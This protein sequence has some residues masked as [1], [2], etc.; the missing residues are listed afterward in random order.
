MKILKTI[1]VSLAVSF[2]CLAAETTDKVQ[3]L[4]GAKIAARFLLIGQ[5]RMQGFLRTKFTMD[6]C[7]AWVVEPDIPAPDGRWAWC[8][9]WPTAFQDRVGVRALLAAG[10]RWVT[11]NPASRTVYAGNQ[12]DEMIAKRRAF[13]R[14]LVEELGYAPKCGLIGMSWGGYYSVRYASTHPECVC[15]A[16]LDAPLLDFTTLSGFNRK[17]KWGREGLSKYY[18]FITDTYV[19][20]DDPYQSVN[21][22][23]PIAKAGIPLLILYGGVDGVVPP[24]SNCL[25]FAAAFEKAGGDL[26]IERRGRYGH[27]P[28]GVEPNEVQR[29]VNFFNRAYAPKKGTPKK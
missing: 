14:F 7:E 10:Y 8:M 28:H 24:E 3:G 11:F 26:M 16:Y 9:E 20:A 27:H 2:A 13:Q 12:N 5:D 15:A 18:P 6:G 25:K 1:A 22:A 21:R 23:E 17:G 4:D 19:G 29:L